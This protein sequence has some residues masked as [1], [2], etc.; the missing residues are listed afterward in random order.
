MMT[1]SVKRKKMSI[2]MKR[3]TER[4]EHFIVVSTVAFQSEAQ[5]HTYKN[6]PSLCVPS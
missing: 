2:K 4:E 1:A 5:I 6:S 3:T